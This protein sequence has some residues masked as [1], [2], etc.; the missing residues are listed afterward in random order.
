MCDNYPVI[1]QFGGTCWFNSILMASLYSE[2]SRKLLIGLAKNWDKKNNF[3]M[4]IRTILLKHYINNEKTQKYLNK[5]KPEAILFKMIKQNDDVSLKTNMKQHIKKNK[6]YALG[7][8]PHY[9]HTFYNFLGANVL[10]ITYLNNSNNY[11]IDIYSL[12]K[13]SLLFLV[14]I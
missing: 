4:I 5:L 2:N 10:D 9:I 11:L 14:I 1:P 12:L 13:I 3:L 6:N 8:Y 7:W